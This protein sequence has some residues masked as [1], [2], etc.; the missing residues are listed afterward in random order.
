VVRENS[1]IAAMDERGIDTRSHRSKHR[2]EYLAQP[3]DYVITVC[4]NTAETCRSSLTP[5][6][7]RAAKRSD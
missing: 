3:F 5:L 1:E 2:N 6:Q 7:S 4:D